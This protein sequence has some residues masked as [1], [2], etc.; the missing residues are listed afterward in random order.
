MLSRA[1]RLKADGI[2]IVVGLVE[3]HGRS[4]T[5]ALID[6]LEVL[7]R[8]RVP[9][10]GRMLEEFDLDAAL[11]AARASSSSTNSPIPTRTTAATPS[12][13]RTSRN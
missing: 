10:R 6:G 11:P 3:T 12:A 9:H 2:D 1:R 13:T 7:P 4:E 8:R 5:A